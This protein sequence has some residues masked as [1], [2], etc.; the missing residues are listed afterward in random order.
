LDSR[1]AKRWSS[2]ISLLSNVSGAIRVRRE[3]KRIGSVGLGLLWRPTV[4][5]ITNRAN[6]EA[7][8]PLEGC[9]TF[10]RSYCSSVTRK[11]R[12]LSVPRRRPGLSWGTM[13]IRAN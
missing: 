1:T 4:P 13:R 11:W 10:S 3:H 5:S 2:N 12:Q 8:G 9:A 7:A 6:S